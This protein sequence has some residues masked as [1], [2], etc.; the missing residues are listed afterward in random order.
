MAYPVKCTSLHRALALAALALCC[1]LPVHADTRNFAAKA[2]ATGDTRGQT[3]AVIDK[4]AA[5]ISL[6]DASGKL[7]AAS[8][9]LLGQAKGGAGV[10]GG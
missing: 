8:P 7:M 2:V 1:A 3:F 9:V 4:T 6:Y 10:F 5:T